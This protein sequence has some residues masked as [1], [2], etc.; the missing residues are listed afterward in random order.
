MSLT[1][2]KLLVEMG[3]FSVDAEGPAVSGPV[4]LKHY[5]P[6]YCDKIFIFN[7]GTLNYILNLHS[8]I[9]KANLKQ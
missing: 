1:W 9:K 8:Q 5:G 2:K 6:R 3:L 4:V 7:H